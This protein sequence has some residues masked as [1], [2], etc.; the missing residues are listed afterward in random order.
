M[1]KVHFSYNSPPRRS[2]EII[3][4]SPTPQQ[5]HLKPNKRFSQFSTSKDWVGNSGD[6][7]PSKNETMVITYITAYPF[8]YPELCEGE[9]KEVKYD[10][11]D[12]CFCAAD[13]KNKFYSPWNV[14]KEY[15]RF[16]RICFYLSRFYI[17]KVK[18]IA[19][20]LANVLWDSKAQIKFGR[21]SGDKVRAVNKRIRRISFHQMV[22]SYENKFFIFSPLWR[23][24]EII[25][26][27]KFSKCFLFGLFLFCIQIYVLCTS[28]RY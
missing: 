21:K 1:V 28:S 6:I 14:N 23:T 12:N 27:H 2:L 25:Q 24:L 5:L 3:P 4:I 22:F 11:Y 13:I 18:I 15:N 7:K 8:L 17:W 26:T 10:S 20:L 16:L 19:P 9:I